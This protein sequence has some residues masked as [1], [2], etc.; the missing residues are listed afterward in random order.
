MVVTRARPQAT[1]SGPK[2][3][4][5]MNSPPLDQSSAAKTTDSTA[6]RGGALVFMGRHLI[7]PRRPVPR[8]DPAGSARAEADRPEQ[9][10]MLRS[11]VLARQNPPRALPR[12][13]RVPRSRPPLFAAPRGWPRSEGPRRG[14]RLPRDLR[15]P[16]RP[17][18]GLPARAVL[19]GKG[20]RRRLRADGPR[21]VAGRPAQGRLSGHRRQR[22]R[23]PPGE[24]PRLRPGG[25]ARGGPTDRAHAGFRKLR[26]GAPRPRGAPAQDRLQ[27]ERRRV[28]LLA[29]LH[30][31]AR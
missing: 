17:G 9:T 7:R 18:A 19:G 21:R 14:P 24:R 5:L 11:A 30:R 27:A 6:L 1:A 31:G 16:A 20:R 13:R 23:R 25:A 4:I 2:G 22:P 3:A 15:R 12:H 10:A 26:R 8:A 28:L 29:D